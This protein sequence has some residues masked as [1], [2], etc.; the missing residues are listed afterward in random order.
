M[1]NYIWPPFT[2]L[3][4]QHPPIF[5]DRA[6]GIFLY[7]KK[8]NKIIDAVSSWWT[9]IHGHSHPYIA[10]K[11]YEQ[12]LKLEHVIFAGFTH[13]P[14]ETL[15]KRLIEEHLPKNFSHIFYSDNGSTAVEVS[16]KMA[17][18]FWKNQ[19]IEKPII[20]ALEHAYHGDTFGSMSVSSRSVFTKAFED[21]LFDVVCIHS[22]ADGNEE[23]CLQE[24]RTVF[25][26]NQ[27]A[28]FIYEP[29]IQG[30]GGMLMYSAQSLEK[31]L[32][33][34]KEFDVLC[35]ADEVMTGF[36]RTGKF[37]AS[38]SCETKP[39]LLCISK[40]L[41]GGTMALG[42]TA[43]SEKIVQAFYSSD[44]D[45]TFYH[46]HSFTANPLAC[47]VACASLELLNNQETID[48]IHTI[49]KSH[50]TF[51][52]RLRQFPLVK[53]IRQTGTVLAFDIQTENKTGY[54]NSIRNLIYDY[55]L[56]HGILLRPLGN[57]IYIMTPY[58]ADEKV[59]QVVYQAI[60]QFLKELE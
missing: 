49:I 14:A 58:C 55:F 15:A 33:L 47:A 18:Q 56:E 28:A 5:I 2:S 35:I 12:A 40:G 16:I 31:L 19:K 41:T 9:N 1:S 60:E 3:A 26:T 30:A 11:L 34:A 29:L 50:N 22:P 38:D 32:K 17:L 46:G 23:K 4:N 59:L 39:D 52:L 21:K 24:L 43:C 48:K 45:K 36:Y 25:Q 7:D 6:E 10:K 44:T 27:V 13:A 20:V 57:T 42:I 37:F 8:G 54:F 51:Q 53:N